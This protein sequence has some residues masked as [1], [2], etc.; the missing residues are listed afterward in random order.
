MNKAEL[1]EA[2]AAETNL[3][4]KDV[5]AVIPNLVEISCIHKG[6]RKRPGCDLPAYVYGAI[7]LMFFPNEKG[8]V[9]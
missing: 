8:G 4:K 1:I 2:I 5:D 3:S 7:H 9:E 6:L